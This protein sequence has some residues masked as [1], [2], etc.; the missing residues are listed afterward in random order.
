MKWLIDSFERGDTLKYIYFW[1][2][3][4]KLN[5]DV[6]K[7]CFS[8]WFES[9]FTVDNRTY[10][11][12]EH[13][14]MSQKALLFD[15]KANFEKILAAES[16]GEAKELGRQVLGFDEQTW[17]NKRFEI[18][19]IGNIHKFNQN[20]KLADYLIKTGDRVL[21]E[22]S[23]VDNIW[24]IGLSQYIK[25]IDNIYA[26]PGLN[27]LGFVLMEVRDFLKYFGHFKPLEYTHQTPWN[28]FPH[29]N[30]HDLFWRTRIGADYLLQF[31]KYYS[32]LTA[33]EK[34]IFKLADP[35]P[36]NWEN[37]YD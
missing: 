34:T 20:P 25:D 13:W 2:H 28:K 32:G 11:T 27:L 10:K 3:T 4:N 14:M 36:N 5:V 8:Q 24:G 31:N 12:T 23:P 9:P 1:G 33:R 19:K 15:D 35:T 29:N 17:N 6:G 37:F 7:F 18:V 16:P 26:W 21:I 22:A 30:K